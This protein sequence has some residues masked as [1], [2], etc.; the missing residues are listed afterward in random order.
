MVTAFIGRQPIYD[1]RLRVVGYELLYRSG[2]VAEA[3]VIDPNTATSEV[4]LNAFTEIGLDD[5]VG[6]RRAFINV[7]RD[8]LI[9]DFP[10]LFPKD[11]IVLEIV[12]TEVVDDK[13][14]AAVDDLTRMGY[15]FALD[16]FRFSEEWAPLVELATIVKL[17]TLALGRDA[18][19]E[20]IELLKPFGVD[21]LAEKVESRRDYRFFLELGF[22]Y[23]QGHAFS[24]AEVVKG[25]RMPESRA[26]ILKLIARLQ[27]PNA[28]I[29]E[30]SDIIGADVSLAYRLLRYINSAFFSLPR[31][32]A[33]SKEAIV[34]L[35]LDRVRTWASLIALSGIRDKPGY[36][37]TLALARGRMCELLAQA[38]GTQ[39]DARFFTVGSFSTLNLLLDL[40]M[41][42]ILRSLP[43]DEEISAALVN[44]EGEL[45]EALRCAIEFENWRLEGISFRGLS[46]ETIAE[47]YLGSTKWADAATTQLIGY[48]PTED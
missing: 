24:R 19:R 40:P 30:L 27:D 31:R 22:R 2:D 25:A 16:D 23:F 46:P 35:G 43:F 28:S 15:E 20:Q 37:M 10:V 32:M 47:S 17:D 5:L 8:F 18:M 7:T 44:Q 33:T 42:E 13:L 12:E 41:D 29:D 48:V 39:D 3:G 45:G 38:A 11:R 21:Y 4:I 9:K 1:R 6:N 36:L 26:A 14:I 34:Y